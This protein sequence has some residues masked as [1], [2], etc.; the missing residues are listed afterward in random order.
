MCYGSKYG[1]ARF[2]LFAAGVGAIC[3]I[4]ALIWDTLSNVDPEKYCEKDGEYVKCGFEAQEA[5][6]HLEDLLSTHLDFK[7]KYDSDKFL[8][9]QFGVLSEDDA[10]DIK[11]A[12]N[13]FF[14][15]NLI[16]LVAM[17]LSLIT[18]VSYAAGCRRFAF[19][20]M[21]LG[22][23]ACIAGAAVWQADGCDAQYRKE[24]DD[25]D[26]MLGGSVYLAYVGGALSVLGGIMEFF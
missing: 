10:E 9:W 19:L 25:T 1:C 12:G 8:A 3:I 20:V 24:D 2:S 4:V 11:R 15:L 5:D 26:W 21:F 13:V 7:Y 6:C 22:G 14:S 17:V 18:G 16:G 23:L